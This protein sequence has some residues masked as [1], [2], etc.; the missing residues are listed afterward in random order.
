MSD[1]N[2]LAMLVV[3]VTCL[4]LLMRGGAREN[5]E[6]ELASLKGFRQLTTDY[7]AEYCVGGKVAVTDS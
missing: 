6:S 3:S 7:K 5:G 2:R 1:K 4:M